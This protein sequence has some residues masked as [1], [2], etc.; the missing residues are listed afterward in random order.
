M[1]ME[2]SS[3]SRFGNSD[4]GSGAGSESEYSFGS[5]SID[6]YSIDPY[7]YLDRIQPSSDL[8]SENVPPALPDSKTSWFTKITGRFSLTTEKMKKSARRF[9]GT[10]GKYP[11]RMTNEASGTEALC[12]CG[13]ENHRNLRKWYFKYHL[14]IDGILS[15]QERRAYMDITTKE[16]INKDALEDKIQ[17]LLL[18]VA[19][20]AGYCPSCKALVD[21]CF[22][23]PQGHFQETH[24]EN[25]LEFE[26]GYR[27]GCRLCTMF[28][29]C[30]IN[31]GYSLET[32]HKLQDRVNCLYDLKI[33]IDIRFATPEDDP[34]YFELT[35][36][37]PG[38][39]VGSHPVGC[40]LYCTKDQPDDPR[41]ST[42]FLLAKCN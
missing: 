42:S 7:G 25:S 2:S 15:E 4:S 30:L 21:K 34:H 28:V 20:V 24:Y 36:L 14:D 13:N 3:I 31:K 6:L 18:Q 32:W 10:E 23:V 16:N 38:I 8:E 1:N 41:T 35:L 19:I 39:T 5:E 37:P 9:L 33:Y 29:Q 12:S 11:N 26:A 40:L 27:N 17:D 22:P